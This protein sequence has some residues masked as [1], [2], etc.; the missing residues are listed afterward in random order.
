M[1]IPQNL[2]RALS[3]DDETQIDT[4]ETALK[5]LAFRPSIEPL[6]VPISNLRRCNPLTIIRLTIFN[7]NELDQD[8]VCASHAHTAAC[9][10][11]SDYH[12]SVRRGP[13]LRC[14]R[15]RSS[16]PEILD[17]CRDRQDQALGISE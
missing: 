4:I 1:L 15:P 9:G 2:L 17:N 13:N 14:I 12:P 3:S 7:D 8:S 6:E 11:L 10:I 16:Y 5:G